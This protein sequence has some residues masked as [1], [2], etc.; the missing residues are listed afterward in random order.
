M[1]AATYELLLKG[2]FKKGAMAT[3]RNNNG[4]TVI[5]LHHSADPN[6]DDAW[7]TDFSKTFPGGRDGGAW[8]SEMDGD[9]DAFAGGLVYPDFQPS[10]HVIPYFDP[11][12]EWPIYRVIDPGVDNPLACIFVA[13]DPNTETLIQFAEHYQSGWPEIDRHAQRIKALTG[14]HSVQYTLLDSSA[15]A[16][17]LAGGGTSVADLFMTHGITV[18]PARRVTHKREL[19][20]PLAELFKLDA[21]G[22]PRAKIM[23]SCPNSIREIRELRWRP[24]AHEDRNAPDEPV[25]FNDHTCDCWGYLASAV[26]PTRA[27]E[28]FAYKDP[29]APYYVGQDRRRIRADERRMRVQLRDHSMEEP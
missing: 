2:W 25:D 1:I 16:K 4:A 22:E 21:R 11:P 15:F 12:L 18:S 27:S 13:L 10:T 20:P 17:T 24:K 14:R 26:N 7:A 28:Q 3:W 29:L 6:K 9:A 5:W 23:D 19:V 8:R